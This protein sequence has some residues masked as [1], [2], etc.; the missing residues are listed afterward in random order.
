MFFAVSTFAG[1]VE[2]TTGG[3]AISGTL[4]QSDG[5]TPLTGKN[6]SIYAFTVSPCSDPDSTGLCG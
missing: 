5:V 2:E 1:S 4:Y 3:G 6:I